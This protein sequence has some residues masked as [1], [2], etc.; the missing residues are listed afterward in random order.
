MLVSDIGWLA[1]IDLNRRFDESMIDREEAERL[2]KKKIAMNDLNR[3][4]NEMFKRVWCRFRPKVCQS[5]ET[6]QR[7]VVAVSVK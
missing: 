5:K 2:P 3:R 7:S 4:P 6:V 1:G